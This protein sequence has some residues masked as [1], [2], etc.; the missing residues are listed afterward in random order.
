MTNVSQKTENSATPHTPLLLDN[1]TLARSE[2]A[3]NA[4]MNRQ[5]NLLGANSY[6]KDLGF[7]PVDFLKK[8]LQSQTQVAWLDLCCGSGRA[9]LQAA[10]IFESDKP[11]NII[12]LVG[13]DLIPMFD[14]IP[15][16]SGHVRLFSASV[17]Q[18]E[19]DEKF[20]LITCVHGLHYVGDKLGALGRASGWMK[21]NGRLIAHVDYRNL[22]IAGRKQ[23][24]GQIGKDLRKAGFKY[25][26]SR[27]L[28]T[29]D[30]K[31]SNRP[32]PY[33]YLGAD[34]KAGPN[35]TGQSAVD[36]Y[37]ERM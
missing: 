17:E 37:Y 36:S 8:V 32:L 16:T 12:Q 19:T 29:R 27:H 9:L 5:R 21:E 28:L 20:D 13:L 15:R 7:S 26:P 14:S 34:D 31:L 33:R 2:I 4:C 30:G 22:K 23:P 18:W 25:L 10:S 24:A 1:D 3:A 35:F 6:E 11:K